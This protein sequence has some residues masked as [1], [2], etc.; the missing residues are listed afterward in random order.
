M[1]FFNWRPKA[2]LSLDKHLIAINKI[3]FQLIE[4]LGYRF[5][6]IEKISQISKLHELPIQDREREAQIQ[7]NIEL[8]LHLHNL[9]VEQEI[10]TIFKSIIHES[11]EYQKKLNL[12]TK[13]EPPKKSSRN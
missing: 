5:H 10:K 4:L 11:I 3:D 2:Q 9:P 12:N 7:K 13:P 1:K 6:H 8:L